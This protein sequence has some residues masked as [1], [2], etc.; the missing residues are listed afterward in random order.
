MS[1]QS[2]AIA[3]I[4]G[5]I[6]GTSVVASLPAQAA[7]TTDA[8][9][10]VTM[11]E[12]TMTVPDLTISGTIRWINSSTWVALDNAGHRPIGIASVQVMSDR[13]RVH[14]DFTAGHVSSVQVTPDEGFAS[15]GVRVGASVGF[16][17]MDIYF[18]MG[19]SSTPVNPTLLSKSGANVWITGT[20]F[21][22]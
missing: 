8:H 2:K 1:T 10:A 12:K 14:Y 17:Y 6:V 16:T 19:T 21:S 20:F 22:D 4:V 7:I 9:T 11:Q 3:V 5:L 13:V 15:A 18:Y